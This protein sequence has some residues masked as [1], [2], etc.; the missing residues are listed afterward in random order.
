MARLGT[1]PV[2]KAFDTDGS[3][4]AS[5]VVSTFITA[6]SS[7]KVTYSSAAE[8]GSATT[9]TLDSNGEAV[10]YFKTDGAYKLTIKDSSGT[11]VRTIDPYI[12]AGDMLVLDD[13]IDVNSKS[14]VSTSNGD[15]AI[16]PNGSGDVV[17]DG[18]K[19]PQA[20]GTTEQVIKTDGSAQLAFVAQG[21]DVVSDTTPQLGGDLDTNSFDIQFDDNTG[22][23]DDAGNQ[24]IVFQKT[25]TAV[26]QID[27]TNAATGNGPTISA[28]GGDTDIAFNL[29]PK[30]TGAVT[31][32][33]LAYPTADG[34]ANQ[35][36]TTDGAGTLSF[37]SVTPNATQAEME[38]ASSEVVFGTPGN[39]H[40]HPGVAKAFVVF[41]NTATILSSFNTTSVADT[42]TGDWLITWGVTFSSV[43]YAVVGA[44]ENTGD[45]VFLHVNNASTTT[46]QV[47]SWDISANAVGETGIDTI[48]AIAFGDLA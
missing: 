25:T 20:D 40:F 30:G 45:L 33:G 11:T 31:I 24:Q 22:I 19:W 1:T 5:G 3:V 18:L 48:S 14:I 15:I 35:A 28:T 8:A 21:T 9:F 12:P 29:T 36:I 13:N 2:F 38:A 42:G 17:L 10:R 16:T 37:A 26:N 39:L 23:D 6:T 4:L 41:D 7:T 47:N 43:D 27:I 46:T 32:D 34:S 44:I